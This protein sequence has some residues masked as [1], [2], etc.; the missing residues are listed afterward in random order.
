MQKQSINMLT[1]LLLLTTLFACN[2]TEE[3]I[4]NLTVTPD[5][6]IFLAEG[7]TAD[8]QVTSN[9]SWNITNSSDWCSVPFLTSENNGK[10]TVTAKANTAGEERL[11]TLSFT[12][13]DVKRDVIIKQK[14]VQSA[15]VDTTITDAPY[16][17]APNQT[18]MRKLTPVDFLTEMKAG[19][20]VGN[21]LDAI[22]GETKWGNPMITQQLIDSVKAAGFNAVRIP[23]AWS[24]FSDETNFIIEESWLNRAEEVVNYVTNDGMYA[25][26]NIHWDGG[27]MQ[28]T[29]AQ[30]EYV[31]NRIEIM[32]DQ[33]ATRF[34]D[35]DDHLLFA[36]TNEV[37][38]TGN[39]S[40]PSKESAAVQNSFNQTFVTT[41]RLTGGRN[42]YRYLVVQGFNTNIDYTINTFV[43]PADLVKNRLIVE[44]HYYDPYNFTIN[45]NS[46][47]TQW[48]KIAS[49]PS[50]AEAWANETW[51]DGQFN[52]LKTK[53]VDKGIPVIIGEYGAM[54]H[55]SV[56]DH[57]KYR[58]YYL[59]YITGSI[60]KHGLT[61]FYWDNGGTGDHGMGIFDRKTGKK[62]YP[63][64]I[65][66]IVD[67][68]K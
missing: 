23:V 34:R 57:A 39:Y 16:I 6:L 35:Y 17:L 12:A 38:V 9:S 22:G 4:I 5:S 27:W 24:K 11:T 52:K 56:A 65:K 48:G 1:I 15:P 59:S 40:A 63:T 67:A 58:E 14:G 13:V 66:A 47:I 36:G 53:F 42:A 44:D 68:A 32:W 25:I 60:Y 7:G 43:M 54:A 26:I 51:A 45:E 64:M 30:K 2:K 19:W 21:S 49:D 61:P 28:P 37:M 55:T 50:K 41:V 31:N 20:N 33:I 62:A 46:N 3:P 8:I 18:G 29:V 10:V